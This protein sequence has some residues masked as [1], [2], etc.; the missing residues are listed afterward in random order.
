[1]TILDARVIS[2]TNPGEKHTKAA[3]AL[4]TIGTVVLL[5][6]GSK[7]LIRYFNSR[8]ILLES[9]RTD[10]V[11]GAF[12][13]ILN[14]Q[15]PNRPDE[16]K[17]FA[18]KILDLHSSDSVLDIASVIK[19]L[20]MMNKVSSVLPSI[21]TSRTS[22]EFKRDKAWLK[23]ASKQ[24]VEFTDMSLR[25]RLLSIGLKGHHNAYEGTMRDYWKR[26]GE[27]MEQSPGTMEEKRVRYNLN[28]GV[29][30]F[31][32]FGP[33][34]LR[35]REGIL[36]IKQAEGAQVNGDI[37][38]TA[39]FLVLPGTVDEKELRSLTLEEAVSQQVKTVDDLKQVPVH[40][41][42]KYAEPYQAINENTV[43]VTSIE[44]MYEP[45]TDQDPVLALLFSL[46]DMKV[47]YGARDILVRQT[48][49][50]NDSLAYLAL[51]NSLTDREFLRLP[52]SRLLGNQGMRKLLI[53]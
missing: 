10:P 3:L 26:L 31:D 12:L 23:T 41:R 17:L 44:Q 49:S 32:R 22:H 27:I 7:A 1:M 33:T 28:H 16:L 8:K 48:K 21:H 35:L 47:Q 13:D 11:I 42:K 43:V 52:E 46:Q 20:E 5:G 19:Q 34:D 9:Y 25:D 18:G 4:L 37:V 39:T 38:S 40:E 15:E 51:P 50:N 45:H 36:F 53:V 14:R 30:N 29:S 24:L 2:P 6:Y